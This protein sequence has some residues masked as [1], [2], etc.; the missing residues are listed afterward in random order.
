MKAKKYA[1]TG[2]MVFIFV[3]GAFILTSGPALAQTQGD[4]A[5]RLAALLGLDSTSP[6]RAIAALT[7]AG[8][9]PKG[10]WN[11]ETLATPAFIGALYA[12]VNS[13]VAAGTITLPAALNNT[14]ALV[15]AA[16]TAAGVPS[17]DAV[18]AIATAGGD[19]GQASTGASFGTAVAAA[20]AAGGAAGGA[21]GGYLGGGAAPGG[22]AGGGGGGAVSP[23]R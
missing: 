22:G 20:P 1:W 12:A 2:L 17:T 5:V 7:A 9:V 14:S 8:I 18:N 21:P 3:V 13:A 11:A 10:G 4:V 16:A 19:R 23:S 15:A 6:D